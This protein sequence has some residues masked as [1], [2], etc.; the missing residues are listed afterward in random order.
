MRV[1]VAPVNVANQATLTAKALRAAGFDAVSCSYLR[2]AYG[3]PTDMCL[4]IRGRI[5][6]PGAILRALSFVTTAIRDYDLFHFHFGHTLLPGFMDLSILR[7]KKKRFLME[8]WG[9][10][11]R[12]HS[13]AAKANPYFRTYVPHLEFRNLRRTRQLGRLIPIALVSDHELYEYVS[14][15]FEHTIVVPQ[16]IDTEALQPLFPAPSREQPLVFHAPTMG[17]IKGTEVVDQVVGRFAKIGLCR[18]L[19]VS[20]KPHSEVM[21]LCREADIVI[22]QLRIGTHGVFALEASA[23]GKPVLTYIRPDLV[24]KYPS[25]LPF[26]NTNPDRLESDLE[27]LLRDGRLRHEIGRRGRAYVER[28]HDLK[29]VGPLLASIYQEL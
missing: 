2:N 16:R 29:K 8:F 28:R 13:R 10:D 14:P 26:V 15:Y 11:V 4:E 25:D 17:P 21:N 18:Y 19:R 22:D 12:L 6:G 7:F 23:L 9:D 27:R 1:L 24:E 5:P 3:F 20:G